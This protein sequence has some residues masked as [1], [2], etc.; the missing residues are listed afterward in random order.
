MAGCS[1]R[2]SSS[3][4]LI[5]EGRPRT[6]LSSGTLLALGY[7]G[8]VGTAL[9]YWAMTVVNKELPAI[10]SSLG[11]LATPAVGIVLSA[12]TLG[13][14][15]DQRLVLSTIVILAGIAIGTRVPAP[16]WLSGLPGT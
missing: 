10:F 15:V 11:V 12:L 1:R 14:A 3:L 5:F 7:N 16:K 9:G 4:A 13:E 6:D 8:V 2:R